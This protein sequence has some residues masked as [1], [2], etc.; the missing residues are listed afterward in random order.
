MVCVLS[1]SGGEAVEPVMRI[2]GGTAGAAG[3]A[4]T[5]G[6]ADA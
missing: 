2:G 1:S 5:A 4:V 6:A 3:L